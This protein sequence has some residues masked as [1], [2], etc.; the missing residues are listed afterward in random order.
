MRRYTIQF[1]MLIVLIMMFPC[2]FALAELQVPASGVSRLADL[3]A[4]VGE[5][6]DT[7]SVPSAVSNY[8]TAAHTGDKVMRKTVLTITD[9][10]VVVGGGNANSNGFG[11]VQIYDFP[12][13]RMLVHGCVV[14][15]LV[16][17]D[18]N[19]LDDADGGDV[20]VGTAVVAD[21]DL[22][23]STDKDLCAAIS[24]D[25]IDGAA[26]GELAASAQF[27]GTSTAKDMFY[28]MNIDSNDITTATAT[29]T[30]SGTVSFT[31]S[32]LGNY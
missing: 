7:G 9:C 28:N 16:T 31:Q 27:D 3:E 19:Y 24:V 25:T 23:D 17:V 32:L 12:E 26:Q 18:T 15:T 14:D 20:A 5:D 10:P 22:T 2:A 11:G 4:T 13:G 30:F 21:G 6:T 8:V 29:N 1:H